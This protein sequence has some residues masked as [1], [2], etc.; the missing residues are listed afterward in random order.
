LHGQSPAGPAG[1]IKIPAK[2]QK[3]KKDTVG[4]APVL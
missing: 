4:P 2:K 1:P 3:R